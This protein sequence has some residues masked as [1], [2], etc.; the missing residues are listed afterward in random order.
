MKHLQPKFL[1]FKYLEFETS[2]IERGTGN[3]PYRFPAPVSVD[4]HRLAEPSSRPSMWHQLNL[5][6][7]RA[8]KVVGLGR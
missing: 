7:F 3:Q 4:A 8:S 1:D 6:R 2:A 5:G